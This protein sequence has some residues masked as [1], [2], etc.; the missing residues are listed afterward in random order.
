LNLDRTRLLGATKTR[1]DSHPSKTAA[2]TRTPRLDDTRARLENQLASLFPQ[3]AAEPPRAVSASLTS[4]ASRYV[5]FAF[6]GVCISLFALS[7]I[8]APPRE[9]MP[10]V[11][12]RAGVTRLAA[13][14]PAVGYSDEYRE[15]HRLTPRASV[16]PPVLNLEYDA[17]HGESA[18]KGVAK[19]RTSVR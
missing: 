11:N 7:A 15:R 1:H 6:V 13:P 2:A 3:A 12:G 4:N 8:P 16:A 18:G 19:R 5:P 9:G 14:M 10:P 17:V